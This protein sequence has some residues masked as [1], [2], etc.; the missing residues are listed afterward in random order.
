MANKWLAHVRKTMKLKKNK[1]KPFG[2]VLKS[3]K[4]TYKARGGNRITAPD[5]DNKDALPWDAKSPP[6][7]VQD[8]DAYHSV[9]RTEDVP[10][11]GR[12][13]RSRRS[14]RHTRK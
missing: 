11:G 1:G 9:T 6:L 12:R 10:K 4:K 7:A 14:S 13:R 2:A 5:V 8:A 3:A